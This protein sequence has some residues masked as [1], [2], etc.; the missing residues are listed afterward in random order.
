[1]RL[2]RRRRGFSEARAI[3]KDCSFISSASGATTEVICPQTSASQHLPRGERF[4]SPGD[5]APV[6]ELGAGG[7]MTPATAGEGVPQHPPQ[8]GRA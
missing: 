6:C 2:Q 4:P 8:P 3:I 1:M 7:G 5:A